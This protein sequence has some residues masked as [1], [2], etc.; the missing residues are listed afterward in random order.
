ME[1]NMRQDG[2]EYE[3]RWR[4]IGNKMEENMRQGEGIKNEDK[5]KEKDSRIK[6]GGN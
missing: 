3:I 4:R 2:G 1:E 5:M 6:R